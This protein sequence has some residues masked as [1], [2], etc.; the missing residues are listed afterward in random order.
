MTPHILT[1]EFGPISHKQ[2]TQLLI[3]STWLIWHYTQFIQLVSFCPVISSAS[4]PSHTFQS[5]EH[6]TKGCKSR[7]KRQT[8][9][10][11]LLW[12]APSSSINYSQ[13][14]Q[15]PQKGRLAKLIYWPKTYFPPKQWSM[16]CGLLF[17]KMH[18]K[19]NI[20][21]KS[22]CCFCFFFFFLVWRHPVAVSLHTTS[23]WKMSE[24]ALTRGLDGSV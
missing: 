23:K 13:Q 24:G 10:C 4:Q 12:C 9:L 11:S 22:N 19:E 17:F 2:A 15:N 21:S 3:D 1:T 20:I 6:F 14:F 8:I 18:R 5:E 7:H 16:F